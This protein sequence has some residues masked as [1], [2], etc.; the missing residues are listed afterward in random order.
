MKLGKKNILDW[1]TLSI[2]SLNEEINL[3]SGRAITGKKVLSKKYYKDLCFRIKAN[4]YKLKVNSVIH[5]YNY[6]ED[7]T[8]FISDIKPERWKVFQVLPIKG[9][10]DTCI[11]DFK[12]SSNQFDTFKQKH[13][14]LNTNGI[15]TIFEDNNAMTASYVMIDPAGRFFDNSKGF[16][17]YSQ[18]ILRVGIK[19]AYEE[20]IIDK[21]KFEQRGGIYDWSIEEKST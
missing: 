19:S 7:F 6:Q 9:E 13:Q 16:L 1:I 11:D 10:N 4:G 14:T 12:L 21:E 8:L 2:D 17:R 15:P 3:I 20:V 18:P 5:T